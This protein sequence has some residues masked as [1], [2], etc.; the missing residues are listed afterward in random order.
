MKKRITITAIVASIFAMSLTAC[1]GDKSNAGGNG[2]YVKELALTVENATAADGFD[3]VMNT[4]ASFTVKANFTPANANKEL[5]ITWSYSEDIFSCVKSEDGKTLTLTAIDEGDSTVS[6]HMYGEQF[7]DIYSNVLKFRV[8]NQ[9]KTNADFEKGKTEYNGKAINRDSL[10]RL[11]N[12]PHLN[13]Q[14]GAH[15]L[16]VP[17]GFQD[18]KWQAKQTTDMIDRIKTTFTGSREE[19]RAKG[20]WESLQSFYQ[21]SSYGISQFEA[22]VCPNWCVYTGNTESLGGGANA[23][24][25]AR[26]WYNTEYA[27]ANHGQLGADAHP[28]TWFDSD[29]DGFIDLIW[30]VYSHDTGASGGDWWAYVTYTN[31]SSNVSNP[32]VKTLGWAGIQWLDES[33]NGYDSHTFIHETGHTFGLDDYY[34]YN[35]TWAPMAG[36]DF[37]DHNMGD[38]NMVSKFMLGWTSPWVVNDDAII[39]LR[40]GT[41]TGDCFLLPSPG[42]NGTAFDEYLMFE[43][44]APVGLAEADYKAGYQSTPGFSK[45]GIR[46]LHADTRVFN[47]DRDTYAK[48]INEVTK[49]KGG[50]RIDNSYGGRGGLKADSDYF[51]LFDA[52]NNLVRSYMTQLSIVEAG[53]TTDLN[54]TKSSTYNASNAS[55]FH[56]GD[57]FNLSNKFKWAETFMPS[58]S[59]LWNK[60]KTIT[61]WT[62]NTTQTYTIDETCTF[63]YEVKVLSIDEDPTY[64]Y[65]A[66]VLVRKDAACY[67][68]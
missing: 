53:F 42:Y 57:V 49:A 33:C 8:E 3:G 63:N 35:H 17:F 65:T 44:M 55:L 52:E 6:A 58:K 62:N 59:N 30:L 22:W 31:S 48:T 25:F 40:P 39:T 64:G 43:L 47:A 2:G 20:G 16:I 46:C 5:D 51:P 66:R 56:T 27:K 50:I 29:Q 61:G 60:A 41:T 18:A 36:V 34:D 15:V 37:M 28:L 12:A 23:A 67:N 1:G 32:S 19:I 38:H 13:N 68:A 11:A 26:N 14:G 10:Y 9:H 45:P 24:S 7:A 54:W 21:T 4:G